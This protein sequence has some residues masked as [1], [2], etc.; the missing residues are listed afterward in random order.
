M[1]A[2]VAVVFGLAASLEASDIPSTY[3]VPKAQ[4]TYD[5]LTAPSTTLFNSQELSIDIGPSYTTPGG[6]TIFSQGGTR[7][8]WGI[9][10]Q[11][12]YWIKRYAGVGIYSGI[13]NTKQRNDLVVSHF[14]PE[15]SGRIPLDLF[16][17]V[18]P[19]RNVSIVA[20]VGEGEDFRNGAFQTLGDAGIDIRLSKHIGFVAKYQR[21]WETGAGG[22]GGGNNENKVV[23]AFEIAF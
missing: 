5:Y 2:T 16:G 1:I 11:A 7:G 21:V 15:I 8:E 10:G 23:T 19:L 14:G 3:V 22:N 12:I 9:E 17:N 4:Q 13:V 18:A 6:T 20:D